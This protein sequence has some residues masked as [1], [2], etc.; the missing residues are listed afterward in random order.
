MLIPAIAIPCR[1]RPKMSTP[2]ADVGDPVQM[3]EPTSM[4][5]MAAWI[6]TCRPKISV[7]WAQKGRKAAEVKLA[8]DMSQLNCLISSG[9]GLSAARSFSD[10]SKRRRYHEYVLKSVAMYGKAAAITV[11]SKAWRVRGPKR[12]MMIFQR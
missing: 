1:A 5:I 12:P 3:A 2:K 6:L 4:T 7:S 9:V 10:C 11:L 8:A